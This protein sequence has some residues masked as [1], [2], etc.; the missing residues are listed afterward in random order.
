MKWEIHKLKDLC[1]DDAPITYGILQ[2]G[3]EVVN[4]VPYVRPSEIKEG[5]IIISSIRR[6][7][8]EIANRYK[9]SIIQQGDLLITI[10]GTIG[11]IVTV[12][13]ELNGGNITQSSARIRISKLKAFPKFIKHF[14]RSPLAVRQYEKHKLGVAVPRLNLHHVRDLKI[15]LPPLEEQKRIAAI[16]DAADAL[17]AKRRESLTQLDTLLQ[18]TFLE[19]FGD[20]VTNPKGW[21][22]RT[23]YE[24]G[25]FVQIGPFGSLLHKEDYIKGGIPLINPKHLKDG[26]IVIGDET[27]TEEKAELLSAYRLRKE[28]VIIGRRGEMGRCAIVSRE[29]A[30]MLCGTGSLFV[31]P[32]PDLL[33]ALYLSKMISNASMKKHLEMV[34]WGVTMPNLNRS[35][36]KSLKLPLP[37][38][39]VQCQFS[40]MIKSIE[41][42]KSCVRAHLDELD[43]LFASLQQRAFN[44]EL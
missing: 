24:T 2:P 22:I 34:A 5:E 27:I 6:T 35:K 19:M 36:I 25:S 31:R 8:P 10:V 23:I 17:R 33:T 11:H 1:C 43:T 12:P 3:P 14:L 13:S 44:G 18:S 20:P 39:E 15:P 29:H 4:G 26:A 30:G 32:N 41:S 28:D 9:K 42:Q 16:L 38:I 40:Q 7:A 21:E 37:P